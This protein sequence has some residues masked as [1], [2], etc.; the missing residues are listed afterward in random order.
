M[1]SLRRHASVGML[2]KNSHILHKDALLRVS[3]IMLGWDYA[4]VASPDMRPAHG[5]PGASRPLSP[6]EDS[7]SVSGA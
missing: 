6:F 2:H 5:A 1:R 7:P 4:V 3:N